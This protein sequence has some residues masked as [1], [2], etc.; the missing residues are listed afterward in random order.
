MT[1]NDLTPTFTFTS[2]LFACNSHWI[3]RKPRYTNR[4]N[5]QLPSF[6]LQVRT[7]SSCDF[8]FLLREFIVLEMFFVPECKYLIFQVPGIN[9]LEFGKKNFVK[10]PRPN[11]RA[12]TRSSSIIPEIKIWND[13]WFFSEHIGTVDRKCQQQPI[14]FSSHATLNFDKFL[15]TAL[16]HQREI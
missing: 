12:K 5:D 16:G 1:L 13:F 2:I 15:V 14:R 7:R 11:E 10:F 3:Q 8:F 4:R 9:L 6:R